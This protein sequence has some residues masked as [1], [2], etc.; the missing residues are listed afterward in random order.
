[1]IQLVLTADDLGF[2]EGTNLSIAQLLIDGLI[3]ATT[4]MPVAQHAEHAVQLFEQQGIQL[5]PAFHACVTSDESM[6]YR[7]LGSHPDLPGATQRNL[8]NGLLGT[9]KPSNHTLSS[10]VDADGYFPTDPEQIEKQG[11]P[12]EVATELAAQYDWLISRRLRPARMDTHWGTIYGL[13]GK[14]FLSEALGLCAARGMTFRLPKVLEPLLGSN[15]PA[16]LREI[17]EHALRVCAAFQVRLPE[18]VLGHF[19]VSPGFAKDAQHKIESYDDLRHHFLNALDLLSEEGIS[20]IFLQPAEDSEELRKATP[21]WQLRVWELQLL[22]DPIWAK[23]LDAHQ[24]KLM[25]NW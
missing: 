6:R 24:V 17:H 18:V 16:N 10:L 25:P 12:E 4:L 13:R 23:E 8:S 20:E 22:R 11:E 9:T 21:D 14:T 2:T 7:P 19:S 3:S 15:I 5:T 1:M